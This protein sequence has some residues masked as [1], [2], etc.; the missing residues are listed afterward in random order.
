M[1]RIVIDL[2]RDLPRRAA[3]PTEEALA[4]IFGGVGECVAANRACG[5]ILPQCC[6]GL[7][8]RRNFLSMRCQ[9]PV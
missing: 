4:R 8:C 2:S 9:P 7:V 5:G 3:P 6:Q 1:S